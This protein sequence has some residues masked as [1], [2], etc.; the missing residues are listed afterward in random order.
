[1]L[2]FLA[3]LVRKVSDAPIPED[4]R[5]LA[6]G[7]LLVRWACASAARAAT[8]ES[9]SVHI[10]YA[11]PDSCPDQAAFLRSLRERTTRFRQAAPDEPARTFLVRVAASDRV[12]SGR[13]EIR[14]PDGNCVSA[15]FACTGKVCGTTGARDGGALVGVFTTTTPGSTRAPLGALPRKP[16]LATI[17][18]THHIPVSLPLPEHL[19]AFLP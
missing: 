9:E 6:G 8:T 12:F 14:S 3:D 1:L 7:A 19:L 16:V 10:D 11:A 5:D 4:R 17:L 2:G 15:G 18:A 13:L